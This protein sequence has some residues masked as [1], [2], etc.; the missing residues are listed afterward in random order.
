MA[1]IPIT[2]FRS[3]A[4]GVL[5]SQLKKSIGST[6]GATPAGLRPGG[7]P[8]T[9]LGMRRDP[10]AVWQHHRS[11]YSTT[12][13]TFPF[14]VE[15]APQGNYVLF[16]IKTYEPAQVDAMRRELK[17][18]QAVHKELLA[19][20]NPTVLPGPGGDQVTQVG[21]D[22]RIGEA[23]FAKQQIDRLKPKIANLEKSGQG[24]GLPTQGAKYSLQMKR[25]QTR[26][27]KKRIALYM[28]PSVSTSYKVN[29]ADAEIGLVAETGLAAFQAFMGA[30][31]DLTSKFTAAFGATKSAVRTLG[32]AAA[33][34]SL[35]TFAQGA[36]ALHQIH[37]DTVITPR[38]ELMFESVG[39][40]SFTYTF[41]FIPKSEEEAQEV[42]KIVYAFKEAMHPDLQDAAQNLRTMA[43]PDTFDI[44]Y[45][46]GGARNAFI[47]KI[48][49]C[50]LQSMDVQ[51]GADRYTAYP[52]AR[53]QF[54]HGK[55]PQKT[56][57]ALTFGE[58]GILT[59]QDI[60][61]GF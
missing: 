33:L 2:A 21:G 7:P 51:Y 32:K 28:P 14:D 42:E 38:M 56:Q 17:T 10:N 53:G 13:L 47:N 30:S 37:T 1:F 15:F 8:D 60:L 12:N 40:R 44:T 58:I 25:L 52:Y 3:L 31:G 6:G 45:M 46:A 59:K 55:P 54:G 49:T 48:A 11:K 61:D 4:G 34:K 26:S 20:I 23:L 39:R 18:A 9:P 50:F 41:V 43:I 57:I 27:T 35:D 29:Y 22:A 16:D 5:A 36:K 24:I 19:V